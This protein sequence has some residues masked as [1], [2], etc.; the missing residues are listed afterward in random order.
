MP[1]ALDAHELVVRALVG[2]QVSVASARTALGRLA[3]AL[4][5]PLGTTGRPGPA[6]IDAD[7]PRR[8]FPTPAAIA[9]EGASVLRGPAA[10]I[11]TIVDVCAR[12]ASGDLVVAPE[13]ERHEL[14]ADLLAVP[15]IGPWT[16]GYLA[17]RVTREPD[18]LLVS[19]LALRNGA[20]RLGL[21]AD[22]RGLAERGAAWAP[23]RSYASMHLWRAASA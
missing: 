23:W 3:E 10:R 16:A 7:G 6:P 1:G 15:G 21:P 18:E 4:G 11:R 2:Q 14:R 22:Q 5:E 8:L 19:D 12:L 20:A 9:A 17:M 13:R